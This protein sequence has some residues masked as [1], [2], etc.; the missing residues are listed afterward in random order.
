VE[1]LCDEQETNPWLM[2]DEEHA[3]QKRLKVLPS[4]MVAGVPYHQ[5]HDGFH[6]LSNQRFL[7]VA[8]TSPDSM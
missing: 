1:V 7:L 5:I 3:D 2:H 4:Q 8:S 6:P